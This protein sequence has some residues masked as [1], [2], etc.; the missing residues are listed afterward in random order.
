MQQLQVWPNLRDGFVGA[1]S[2]VLPLS[3]VH[4]SRL[5]AVVSYHVK[6]GLLIQCCLVEWPPVSH[7]KRLPLSCVHD[8]ENPLAVRC[9][10]PC[11]LFSSLVPL[12]YSRSSLF[13]WSETSVLERWLIF[14]HQDFSS[15]FAFILFTDQMFSSSIY[16]LLFW[17]LL[18]FI[19]F[20]PVSAAAQGDVVADLLVGNLSNENKC[21]MS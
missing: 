9:C 11:L 18:I 19:V 14:F 4:F 1:T 13:S 5:S 17:T 21:S 3:F 16:G 15:F 20:Y 2:I 6:P 7:E 8:Q 10:D 12:G